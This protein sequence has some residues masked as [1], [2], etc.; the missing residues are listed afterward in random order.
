VFD[1][2]WNGEGDADTIIEK[3]GLK[4]ITDTDELEAIVDKVIADNPE[5]VEQFRAG[6]EKVL[7]FFVGQCM[8][9]TGGKGNP[10]Q[11]NQMLRDKLGK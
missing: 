8:K 10:A 9:A 11:L 2:M 7:G 1:A 3:K 5:Q 6:K 4:Q